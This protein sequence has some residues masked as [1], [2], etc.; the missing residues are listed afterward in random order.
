MN[1]DLPIACR[2]TEPALQER[3]NTVLQKGGESI[4][5]IRELDAGFAYRFPPDDDWLVSL[6][7]FI[8]V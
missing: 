2:L 4:L 6:S 5:E 3:R 7:E 8:F 1:T